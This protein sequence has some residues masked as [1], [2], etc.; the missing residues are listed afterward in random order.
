[1]RAQLFIAYPFDLVV[2]GQFLARRAEADQQALR[3]SCIEL[4]R[5]IDLQGIDLGQIHLHALV[6][7]GECLGFGLRKVD[8]HRHLAL[9]AFHRHPP[10]LARIVVDDGRVLRA[11]DG[12]G[13]PDEAGG[14]G[15]QLGQRA[16]QRRPHQ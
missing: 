12:S 9:A 15:V 13:H 14:V 8:Q 10:G 2:G 11:L 3:Q 1:M 6:A 16:F 5:V 4:A 7:I